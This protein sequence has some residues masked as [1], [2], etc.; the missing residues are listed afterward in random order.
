MTRLSF[1]AYGLTAALSSAAS[2]GSQHLPVLRARHLAP[3]ADVKVFHVAGS[4]RLIARK[5]SAQSF[6]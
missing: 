6:G 2:Q 5:L 4:I 1:A 3:T